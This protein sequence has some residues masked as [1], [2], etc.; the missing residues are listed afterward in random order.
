M[1]EL[2]A[3]TVHIPRQQFIDPFGRMVG[4]PGQHLSQIILGVEPI[5]FGG[6]DQ[7]I[8]R[9]RAIAARIRPG[10]QSVLAAQRHRPHR[11]FGGV[12]VDAG[13]AIAQHQRHR[14]P[15]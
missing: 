12:V 8:R 11:S 4:D 15:A 2:F 7:A 10:E 14:L 6:F 13:S 5:Q 9:G 1:I 3:N